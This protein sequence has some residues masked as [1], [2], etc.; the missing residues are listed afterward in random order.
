MTGSRHTGSMGL[1]HLLRRLR[2][3]RSDRSAAERDRY[4][5]AER[6]ED[7]TQAHYRSVTN[8]DARGRPSKRSG[9]ST[10]RS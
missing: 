3:Q 4:D 1:R 6:V 7:E 2:P 10:R 5:V 8:T 9:S